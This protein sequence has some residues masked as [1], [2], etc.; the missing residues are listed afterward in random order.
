LSSYPGDISTTKEALTATTMTTSTSSSSKKCMP[1]RR[2]MKVMCEN[3]DALAE[4]REPTPLRIGADEPAGIVLNTLN[5]LGIQPKIMVFK[6][7]EPEPAPAK[8]PIKKLKKFVIVSEAELNGPAV[9]DAE[10]T[11]LCD[12]VRPAPDAEDTLLCDLVPRYSDCH[13]AIQK[14]TCLIPDGSGGFY[15]VAGQRCGPPDSPEREDEPEDEEPDEE[16]V[17][18]YDGVPDM[19]WVRLDCDRAKS[20]ANSVTKNMIRAWCRKMY[21][22]TWYEDENKKQMMER[23]KRALAKQLK[24]I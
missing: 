22:K 16:Y 4:Y 15:K 9:P 3:P 12:L 5:S 10:D 6:F 2:P 20:C 17:S 13:L 24:P 1:W 21:G 19:A 18:G 8:K 7:P 23:A 11:L 14:K